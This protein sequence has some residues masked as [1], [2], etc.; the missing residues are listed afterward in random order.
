MLCVQKARQRGAVAGAAGVSNRFPRLARLQWRSGAEKVSR[1]IG[2]RG[3]AVGLKRALFRSVKNTKNADVARC[4][5]AMVMRCRCAPASQMAW[6]NSCRHSLA[7]SAAI[8]DHHCKQTARINN[9]FQASSPAESPRFK[10]T[11]SPCSPTSPSSSFCTG[12]R[13]AQPK[14]WNSDAHSSR[15]GWHD[16]PTQNLRIK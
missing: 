14:R 1:R 4:L 3:L 6:T 8:P 16:S 12:T 15:S 10:P 5:L 7:G 2:E 11:A 9:I 13:G